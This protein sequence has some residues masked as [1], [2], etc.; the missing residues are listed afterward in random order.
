[1]EGWQKRVGNYSFVLYPITF[2]C[3]NGQGFRDYGNGFTPDLV[4]DDS[5]IYPGE[6]G[7]MADLLSSAALQWASSGVKPTDY[8][9]LSR[10]TGGNMM[11]LP[12]DKTLNEPLTRRVGGSRTQLNEL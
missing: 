12:A 6:F 7:T 3:E 10:S 8:S 4:I 5:T 9:T 2:Y 11:A 1:M